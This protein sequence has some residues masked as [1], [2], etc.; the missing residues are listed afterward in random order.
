M[1]FGSWDDKVWSSYKDTSG[2]SKATSA[3]D[4]YRT[5]R[6]KSKYLPY[7]VIRKSCDSKEHP[8]TTPIILGLDVTGS[9][10]RILKVTADKLGVTAGELIKRE[11]VPGPQ[12]LFA[13]ID[14]YTTSGNE[15]LQV[16]QFESD[17][18]MAKQLTELRF[19][20][21]GGANDYESYALAWYF[22]AKHT[23][24]DAIQNGRKGI[25]IT[26]GDDGVQQALR[27]EEIVAVFGDKIQKDVKVSALLNE[28]NRDWEVFHLTMAD[29][30]TY[31]KSLD[32]EWGDLLG[33]HSIV[34]EDIDKIPEII[35]SLIQSLGGDSI[36]EIADTWDGSTAIVVKNALSGLAVNRANEN[37][38][39][40]VF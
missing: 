16:T 31:S 27:K 12:I 11:C 40:V 37:S 5:T 24:C 32:R 1:G 9:M 4:I 25:I 38:G 15:A 34:V 8:V 17:I 23:K 20:G 22:A 29:G 39:V 36:D 28:L 6:T 35:V 10:N 13:A 30:D 26:L 3:H 21:R 7:N 33:T 18:E 14:D 19:I 2:I